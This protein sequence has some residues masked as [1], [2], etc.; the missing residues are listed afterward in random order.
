M[1]ADK[2]KV[3]EFTT[4]KSSYRIALDPGK[5]ILEE[6]SAPKKY[7]KLK[8]NLVFTVL[9]DGTIV[10]DNQDVS[11]DINGLTINVYNTV[12]VVVPDTLSVTYLTIII[13]ILLIGVGGFILYK[14]GYEKI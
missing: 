5:Y 14:K 10:S 1:K 9:E 12:P 6:V 3:A 2:T 11:F 13:G 4:S 8:N 7:E